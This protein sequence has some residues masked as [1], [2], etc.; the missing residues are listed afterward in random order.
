MTRSTRSVAALVACAGV[1]LGPRAAAQKPQFRTGV[2]LVVVDALVTDRGRLVEGLKAED[3]DLRDEGV[4]QQVGLLTTA[5]NVNLILA[6]DTSGSLAGEK[7]RNLKN[8]SHALIAALRP[9]DTGS[10][11]SFSRPIELLAAAERDPAIIDRALDSVSAGGRTALLDAL[12]TALAVSSS[13][14]PRSLV[15]LFSDGGENASWLQA[16]SVFDSL[17]H[18]SVVVYTVAAPSELDPR[19]TAL[20]T[21]I[22]DESGGT[23]LHA[24]ADRK[25]S[26]VFVGILNEFR[27]R[28]LLT[29][30][31]S[32]VK[33]GDGWHRISVKLKDKPG[34]VTARPG[35]FARTGARYNQPS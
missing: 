4:P 29:Y 32:G 28:Y 5:G 22:A 14:M 25:L 35:Y 1:L 34:R 23:L 30:T 21:R 15:I 19:G 17:R 8:A 20:L 24:E 7:R 2:E 3:F 6:L 31:P 16:D 18:A 26:G 13:D 33:P 9:G 10:L 11:L 12:Y 27:L